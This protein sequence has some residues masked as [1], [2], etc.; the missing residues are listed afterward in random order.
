VTNVPVIVVG[1]GP[2]G[3]CVGIALSRWGVPC[4]LVE[5]HPAVSVFP[6]SR[7]V[8]QRTMEIFRGW[9]IEEVVRSREI[10]SEP[11]MVWAQT[12]AGPV[13][14][15]MDY[16][17]AADPGLSPCRMSSVH[18]DRLEPVLLD[19]L[20]GFPAAQVR[21]GTEAA[22]ERVDADG[23]DVR[24]TDRRTGTSEVVRARFVIAADGA[25]SPTRERLSV[26]MRGSDD[27]GESL[28]IRFRADLS[29]FTGPLPAA[30][31]FLS[32]PTVRALYRIS[33]NDEWVLNAEDPATSGDPAA[34]VRAAIGADVP[35]QVLGEPGTWTAAAQV[36][37]R[38][39]VG[40]VLLAGDAAHRLTPVGGMGMNTGVHD[41]HNLAW[42]LAAVLAGRAGD[43]LLDTYEAERQPVAR[44][45]VAWSLSNWERLRAGLPWPAP[46]SPN[47]QTVDLGLDDGRARA[48]VG[49]RAPHAWL[50]DGRSTLDLFGEHFTLLAAR[51]EWAETARDLDLG[52]PLRV[53][54]VDGWTEAYA[55]TP[56]TAV[57]V[58]PDG[59]IAWRGDAASGEAVSTLRAA[60][61]GVFDLRCVPA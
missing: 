61:A 57:L 12:L 27:L 58:R 32:G 40:P 52:L 25:N 8:H 1:A 16:V 37:D 3:L 55:A 6:R 5:R 42:K 11:I 10:A 54:T 49:C 20:S 13:L 33:P 36:A 43:G 17:Q 34:A 14:R 7:S 15:R 38:L 2:T 24:L 39:R 46:G 60:V 30:F 51:P 23:A 59:H 47:T 9:G 19:V 28:L 45:N 29:R 50:R 4:L 35:V 44:R 18:Q 21:F 48:G 41:V 26:A 22:V 56:A 31:Y 53:E